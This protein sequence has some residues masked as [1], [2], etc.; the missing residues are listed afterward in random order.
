MADNIVRV[1]AKDWNFY[2]FP[3]NANT[4]EIGLIEGEIY[5]LLIAEDEEKIVIAHQRFPSENTLRHVSAIPRINVVSV[6]R[7]QLPEET[8]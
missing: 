1:V 5:G 8:P 3:V 7:F 2:G 4:T 6:T